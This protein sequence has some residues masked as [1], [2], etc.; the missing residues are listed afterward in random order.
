MNIWR[1][2]KQFGVMLAMVLVLLAPLNVFAA[3]SV[4]TTALTFTPYDFTNTAATTGT[5]SITLSCAP[6]AALV[7]VA[8]GASTNSGGF[9]PRRMKHST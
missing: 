6:P 2:N 1:G 7:T 3:C 5:G 8:I 9:S 4:S